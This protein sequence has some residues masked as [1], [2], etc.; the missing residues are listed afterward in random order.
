[1][2]TEKDDQEQRLFYIALNILYGTNR[3]PLKYGK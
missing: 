1:M 3:L 2:R